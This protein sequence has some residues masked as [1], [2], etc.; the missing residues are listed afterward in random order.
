MSHLRAYTYKDGMLS[1]LSEVDVVVDG[2]TYPSLEHAYQASRCENPMDFL[3]GGRFSQWDYVL[4][5]VSEGGRRVRCRVYRRYNA[6]GILALLV[7]RRPLTFGLR[8]SANDFSEARWFPLLEAKF[9][10]DL[11]CELLKTSGTLYKVSRSATDVRG[12]CVVDGRLMGQNRMGELLTKFRDAKR[13]KRRREVEDLQK[14]FKVA[15]ERGISVTISDDLIPFE[16][17]DWSGWQ[18]FEY[19]LVNNW[20]LAQLFEHS[21]DH[22]GYIPVL[23][24]ART[25]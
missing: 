2:R 12:A 21:K 8:Q 7:S 5:R 6:V 22:A 11:L 18:Q 23:E 15:E 9:K 17:G 19:A 20:T 25:R 3:K 4:D 10:G 24:N 1:T 16:W 13:P 14:R